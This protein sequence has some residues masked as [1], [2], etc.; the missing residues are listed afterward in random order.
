MYVDDVEL[1]NWKIEGWLR[2]A[3]YKSFHEYSC[4]CK[5]HNT[6]IDDRKIMQWD[7]CLQ[8]L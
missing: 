2:N 6:E 5:Y 3:I 1:K 4:F 7:T 8:I